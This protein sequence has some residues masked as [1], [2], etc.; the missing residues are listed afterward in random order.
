M[1]IE[2]GSKL[3]NI[4]KAKYT[5]SLNDKSYFVVIIII[6]AA[7][8]GGQGGMPP[9]PFANKGRYFLGGRCALFE[10]LFYNPNFFIRVKKVPFLRECRC[11]DFQFPT[12]LLLSS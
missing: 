12:A 7:G 2:R 10:K 9:C 4:S 5:C 8:N 3:G 6:R 11:P 1:D